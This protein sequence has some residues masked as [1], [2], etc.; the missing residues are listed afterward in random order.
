MG[1]SKFQFT[2]FKINRS[3][4]ERINNEPSGKIKLFFDPKG[5]INKSEK[6]FQLQLGVRIEDVN[7][8]FFIEIDSIGYYT[9]Q[10]LEDPAHLNTFFYTNA[11]A[12]LFP[13]LRAYISTLT[14]L[15][16]FDPVNLPTLNL[17]R[18]GADLKKNT[19]E[20]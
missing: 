1:D 3:L 19:S 17:T 6:T 12:L 7:K 13:Y 11:P 2:G 10:N 15:S 20:I 16:G 18:L 9:F 14:N 5:I 4:I 8:S